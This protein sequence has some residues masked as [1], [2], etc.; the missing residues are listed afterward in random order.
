MIYHDQ[1]QISCS[2]GLN[3]QGAQYAPE[4]G[5]VSMLIVPALELYL[6]ARTL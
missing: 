4:R 6:H 5:S 3:L 1:E 2:F